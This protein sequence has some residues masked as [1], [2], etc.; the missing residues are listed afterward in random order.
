V[1]GFRVLPAGNFMGMVAR[2]LKLPAKM[3][4]QIR[5]AAHKAGLTYSEAA[6]RA[7][8]LGL[9]EKK[10]VLM[11]EALREFAGSLDGPADLSTNKA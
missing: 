11:L 9:A 10:G 7:L 1:A 8:E 6:R 3:D 5:L 4:V 2:T